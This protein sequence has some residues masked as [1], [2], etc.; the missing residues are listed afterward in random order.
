MDEW[1][2]LSDV[3]NVATYNPGNDHSVVV[4]I[5]P[6]DPSIIKN[7]PCDNTVYVGS[8]VRVNSSGVAINAIANDYDNS[9]V[10]GIVENK[11][12]LFNCDIRISGIT[13]PI[14]SALD[15]TKDYYLSNTVSGAM[16]ETIPTTTGHIKLKLGQAFSD[17]KFLF[18]K[19][20]RVVRL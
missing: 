18:S 4:D 1:A 8:F 19:G 2:L 5:S 16:T 12:T 6:P 9:N 10:I 7:T 3:D 11:N 15:T 13:S 17:T 20:E 14:F